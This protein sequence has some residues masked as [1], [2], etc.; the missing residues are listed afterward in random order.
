VPR[1]TPAAPARGTETVLLVEDEER[2]RAILARALRESGYRVIAASGGAEALALGPE[3]VEQTSILVTDLVMPGLDGRATA[4]A[5]RRRHPALPVLFVSGYAEEEAH[6]GD[7]GAAVGFLAKPFS[8]AALLARVRE[9]LDG[10]DGPRSPATL[11]TWNAAWRTDLSTGIREVD[12]QHRELLVQIATLEGAA[13]AGDLAQADEA[14]AYLAR[15]AAEHFATEERIMRELGYP[16]L[17][18]HRALHEAF[19]AELAER[20]VAHAR[21]RSPVVLLLDLARWM[22]AW[23]ADHVLGADAEMARFCRGRA[24]APA[25]GRGINRP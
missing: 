14:L 16:G 10:V 9:L 11:P 1:P 6:P 13:R 2:L 24:D 20:K 19:S 15:Y 8:P 18:S 23:L 17:E 22:E 12:H 4:E 7:L 21:E 3:A 5:L 25:G